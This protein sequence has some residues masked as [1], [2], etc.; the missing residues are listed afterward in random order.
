MNGPS[1]IKQQVVDA[2][3]TM[4]TSQLTDF[5]LADPERHLVQIAGIASHLVATEQDK[6]RARDLQRYFT[7]AQDLDPQ[8]MPLQVLDRVSALTSPHCR[9]RLVTNFISWA[10]AGVPKRQA[11]LREIGASPMVLL[12]SPS[13]RCNLSCTGCYASE[14]S[15][16]DDLPM[17]VIDRIVRE[18]QDIGTYAITILG[19]EPFIRPDLLDLFDRHPL[20]TFQVFTNGTLIDDVLAARLAKAGNVLVSLSI[21]G[22][23]GVH[24]ERRGPGTLAAVERAMA[25]LRD[26]GVP[27]GFSTMVTRINC[28]IVIEDKYID[29]LMDQGCLWGWHFLYMPVGEEPDLDLMP[30]PQQREYLRVQGAS[31][32]RREKPLFVMDFWNDAPYVG[33]CIAAG[34][35]YLHINSHGD[36]EPCIFTHF[37]TDNIKDKSLA[38]VLASPFFKGIR[39]RQPYSDNLLRPC[40]LID[41]TDV[42]RQV[43]ADCG[44]SPTHRNA[45]DLLTLMADDLD[46]YASHYKVIADAVWSQREEPSGS[47]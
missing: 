37:A 41:N 13:M 21:D 27:F 24:D 40:M 34:K 22:P 4:L 44:A 29:Y 9:A 6:Q 26:H 18:A 14:Y 3:A 46:A 30:T 20:M 36:V 19:G 10:R 39:D 28:P 1:E 23:G 43:V 25:S 47:R 8:P 35:E 11:S 12:I 33:G 31:R 16:A 7:N 38:E 32:I 2:T 15:R 42:V 45:E 5:L 17:D